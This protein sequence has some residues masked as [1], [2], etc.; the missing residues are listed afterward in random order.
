MSVPGIDLNW[1]SPELRK[2]QSLHAA[3]VPTTTE[4]S[5]FANDPNQSQQPGPVVSKDP[6]PIPGPVPDQQPVQQQPAQQQPAHSEGLPQGAQGTM[7]ID[8]SVNGPA[9]EDA[10]ASQVFAN[11]FTAEMDKVDEEA[12][13]EILQYGSDDDSDEKERL[14]TSNEDLALLANRPGSKN[15]KKLRAL[16]SQGA[17]PKQNVPRSRSAQKKDLVSRKIKQMQLPSA[18]EQLASASPANIKN[19][20]QYE[21]QKSISKPRGRF[22][23]LRNILIQH[24]LENPLDLVGYSLNECHRFRQKFYFAFPEDFDEHLD[25]INVLQLA[26]QFLRKG[27]KSYRLA[28]QFTDRA[29]WYIPQEKKSRVLHHSDELVQIGK[30]AMHW[31]FSGEP[32]EEGVL[33][34]TKLLAQCAALPNEQSKKDITEAIKQYK[35]MRLQ[36]WV[37]QFV[38]DKDRAEGTFVDQYDPID[39][40]LE[41]FWHELIT[42]A[43]DPEAEFIIDIKLAGTIMGYVED[44]TPTALLMK[45]PSDGFQFLL[46][47]LIMEELIDPAIIMWHWQ[48]AQVLL[49][50]GANLKNW[51]NALKSCDC[52]HRQK[53]NDDDG[54]ACFSK[55]CAKTVHHRCCFSLGVALQNFGL[56]NSVV[57]MIMCL[58]DEFLSYGVVQAMQANKAEGLMILQFCHNLDMSSANVGKCMLQM[59]QYLR[60]NKWQWSVYLKEKHRFKGFQMEV[61]ES[62]MRQTRHVKNSPALIA[63][64]EAGIADVVARKAAEVK[65]RS[66]FTLEEQERMLEDCEK[67][68]KAAGMHGVYVLV[69]DLL[70]KLAEKHPSKIKAYAAQAWAV[71]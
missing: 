17:M 11:P 40:D 56:A 65:H 18:R 28:P 24:M 71:T 33:R 12:D 21:A 31:L 29:T 30:L 60:W 14:L 20:A 32:H 61:V 15:V 51:R 53:H 42:E 68:A 55:M 4:T 7:F 67:K 8:T 38:V 16:I 1:V 62:F 70:F 66:F 34:L 3:T 9:G 43:D 37:K 10:P 27:G 23:V 69:W 44:C 13:E 47:E 6:I 64:M 59:T 35:S 5:S 25:W 39:V 58:P 50:H 48:F 57:N 46:D 52:E 41:E 49:K 26:Y 45:D 36:M 22:P 63:E 19:K 54:L 2:V